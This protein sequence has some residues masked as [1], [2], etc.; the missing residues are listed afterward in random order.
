M[1]EYKT[2]LPSIF[3]GLL[4]SAINHLLSLDESSADGLA[5]LEGKLL[6]VD[7]EG[8]GIMLFFTFNYGAV[9]V[10]LDAEDEPDTIITGSPAA[11]F[12]MAAP[13][14]I[15]DWGLPGSG[16]QIQGDANLARDIGNLFSRLDPDWARP[17]TGL[18]GDT[19]GFQVA[20]GIKQ[21][22]EALGQAARTASD[23][24]ATYFRDTA[25][26]LVNQQEMDEFTGEVDETREAVDRLQ[27]RVDRL[28]D[29]G[30]E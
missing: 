28:R 22:A 21:G 16:V 9:Q 10:G 5:R 20:S 15:S 14:E 3:A 30:E 25:A 12:A 13:D 8:M 4:E 2:P 26:V 27:A 29:S 7:L 17:L 24:A 1:A 11:L 18:L 6:R 23:Q 19:L